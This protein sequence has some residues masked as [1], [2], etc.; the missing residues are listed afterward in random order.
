MEHRGSGF[1]HCGQQVKTG[2]WRDSQEFAIP[3][4]RLNFERGRLA[5]HNTSS[6]RRIE[7]PT[8][9]VTDMLTSGTVECGSACPHLQNNATAY[10]SCCLNVSMTID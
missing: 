6:A 10:Q 9:Q 7:G 3:S 8:L 4:C 5:L 2:F 1:L